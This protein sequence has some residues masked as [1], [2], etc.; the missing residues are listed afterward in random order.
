MESQLL[1]TWNQIA[2]RGYI[3][4]CYCFPCQYDASPEALRTHLAVALGRLSKQFPDLAGR[5]FFMSSNAGRLC[6]GLDNRAEIPLKIF[7]QRDSFLWTY[8]QL[9]AEG[10]PARAFVDNSFDLPYQLLEDQQGIP[11]FEVHARLIRGGLLLCIY[12]HHSIS[13]GTGMDNYVKYFAEFTKDLARTLG[14]Q[15]TGNIHIDLPDRLTEGS[16]L[17]LKSKTFYELLELCTE[18]CRLPSPTGPTQFHM[19]PIDTP[20][21]SIQKTGRIFVIR[22]QQVN[23]LKKRL[24]RIYGSNPIGRV[25]STFIC[26]AAITWAHVTKA[27]LSTSKSLLY[28]PLDRTSS[29]SERARLMISINW[30][31][32]AFTDVMRLSAGNTVALPITLIDTNIIFAA[33]SNDEDAAYNALG[34]ITRAIDASIL[35]VDEDFTVLRT[36]LFRAAPDPRFIGLDFDLQDPCNFY[37][38]T[39]QHFGVDT[40]WKLPGLGKDGAIPDAM[41]RAQAEWSM[42]SGLLLPRRRDS[43]EFE[44][45]VTLHVDE[46]VALCSEPSWQKWVDRVVE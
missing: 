45:L 10:F 21:E 28:S 1:S 42:G 15:D 8:I 26:L 12:G 7:D 34:T 24:T 20:L 33:C 4:Q 16:Q 9:K 18:Y 35:N 40:R 37:F 11:V 25:P 29:L 5:I 41:R 19:R 3:R 6:I 32:R 23:R 43:T 31:R 39:W 38:N 44:V 22:S 27:R 13:D 2:P 14:I 46:I 17:D 36:A 30:R